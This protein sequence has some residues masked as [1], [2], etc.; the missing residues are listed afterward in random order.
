MKTPIFQMLSN[1]L[2]ATPTAL[3]VFLFLWL[4][5]WSCHIWC[6]ILLNDIMDLHI[7]SLCK[8]VLEELWWVFYATRCQVYWGLTHNEVFC[9]YSD[10]ISYTTKTQNTV[11]GA[12][13]WHTYKYTFTSLAMCSQQLSFLPWMNNPLIAKMYFSQCLFPSKIIY[14]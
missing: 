9:W 7:M 4:N 2:I 10:L 14:L 5:G 6:T 8:L 13:E 1:S 3:F 11:R 12:V